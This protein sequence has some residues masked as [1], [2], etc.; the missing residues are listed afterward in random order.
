MGTKNVL[1]AATWPLAPSNMLTCA[2]EVGAPHKKVFTSRKGLLASRSTGGPDLLKCVASPGEGSNLPK[3]HQPLCLL[4]PGDVY[5]YARAVTRECA[6]PGANR[7]G[8]GLSSML[9]RE[10]LTISLRLMSV[11]H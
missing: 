6:K 9:S 2:P 4:H 8:N 7:G 5:L 11:R 3:S 1:K 10:P